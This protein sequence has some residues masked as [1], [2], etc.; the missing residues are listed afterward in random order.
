MKKSSNTEAELKKKVAYEKSVH[1]LQ[2][3]YS[4]KVATSNL[5]ILSREMNLS[6]EPSCLHKNI[7]AYNALLSHWNCDQIYP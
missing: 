1:Y 7:Q 3:M 2:G 4:I 5:K 6:S